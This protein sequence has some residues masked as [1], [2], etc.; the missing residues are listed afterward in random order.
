MSR[1]V[2]DPNESNELQVA[3]YF[4]HK[5]K[6]EFM[7]LPRFYCVDFAA[8]RDNEMVAWVEIKCRTNPIGKYNTFRMAYNKYTTGCDLAR[9]SGQKFIL[10][11]KW[12][13][14]YGYIDL[15]TGKYKISFGGRKDRNDPNDLEPQV[16]IPNECF[17]IFR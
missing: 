14:C 9:H 10:A 8:F 3:N 12:T 17:S 15:S 2:Y 4:A 11:V 13:D 6:A 16:E 1:S 7:K 5:F